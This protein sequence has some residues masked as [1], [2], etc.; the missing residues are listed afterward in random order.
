MC[1]TAI[2]ARQKVTTFEPD[3]FGPEASKLWFE[4]YR[5][6]RETQPV[7]HVPGSNLYVL[8]R[9]DD[10]AMVVR[11]SER[12]SNEAEKHG[13]EPLL[14][15]P[16]ARTIYEQKGWP[17]AFPLAID[18]PEH[19]RYRSLINHFFVGARLEASRSLIENHVH[20]LIDSF[21]SGGEIEFVEAFA[22]P[23]PAAI[24]TEL[25]G[26]PSEDGE[27]L[28]QW[29]FAWALP[30]SRGLSVEQEIWV[31]EQGVEFQHYLKGHVDQRRANPTGDIICELAHAE[32]DGQLL[33]DGDIVQIIDHLFI[34][35]NE[36]TAFALASGLWMM[37]RDP[38]IRGALVQDPTRIKAFVEEVL[39]LESPTQGLYRTATRDAEIRGVKIPKGATLHLRFAAANRDPQVFPDP[40]NIR[41]DRSNAMQHMAFSQAEH[42]CP[43]SGLSRLELQIAFNAL[44]TRL[45]DM[46]LT[47]GR[48]DFAHHPG[49]VLRAL[50]ALHI[51]CPEVLART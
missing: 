15:C 38:E 47:E 3:L 50:K 2:F 23:L 31:A 20:R 11:D 7:Y 46:A 10:I 34:G 37:L 48:N 39:R 36:T 35:G 51:T 14:L 41:F 24:I 22:E 16:A 44:I 43:G 17:K 26:L 27:R 8:T 13:G 25:L 9:H 40:D 18:P 29:S 32:L 5:Q 6:L 45:P 49:F 12:F 28:K 19:R 42:H 30:F 21:G 1:K 4:T 33:S